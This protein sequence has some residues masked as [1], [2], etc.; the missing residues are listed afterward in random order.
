MVAALIAMALQWVGVE[1]RNQT[2]KGAGWGNVQDRPGHA[3]EWIVFLFWLA[4]AT[5][6]W[7]LTPCFAWT[8]AGNWL[9]VDPAGFL[10]RA[11]LVGLPLGLLVWLLSGWFARHSHTYR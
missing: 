2:G 11:I 1:K 5:L 10:W 6:V 3:P 7:T 9:P 8:R 4:P